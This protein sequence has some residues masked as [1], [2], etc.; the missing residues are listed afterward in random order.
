MNGHINVKNIIFNVNE[1]KY[2]F[3]TIIDQG[4]TDKDLYHLK[5]YDPNKQDFIDSTFL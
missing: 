3:H 5:I 1:N 4:I 2:L